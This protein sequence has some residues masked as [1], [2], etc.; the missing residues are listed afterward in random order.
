[1][2]KHPAE[3]HSA[4][5]LSIG[6]KFIKSRLQSHREKSPSPGAPRRGQYPCKSA[7]VIDQPHAVA[8]TS[9]CHVQIPGTCG[10]QRCNG[11]GKVRHLF[12]PHL[13]L[14]LGPEHGPTSH[15]PLFSQL[16]LL[17]SR[18]GASL[19]PFI[20]RLLLF[21]SPSPQFLLMQLTFGQM[22]RQLWSLPR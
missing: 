18:V 5:S 21:Y 22:I 17:I 16:F 8:N 4:S 11:R 10:V 14:S 19:L 13:R 9:L 20:P 12:S 2:H 6:G 3:S 15:L 7:L 1:M